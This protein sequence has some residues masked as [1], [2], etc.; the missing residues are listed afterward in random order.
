M[1]NISLGFML[2]LFVGIHVYTMQVI[3]HH[4][5]LGRNDQSQFGFPVSSVCWYPCLYPTNIFVEVHT[6]PLDGA[7]AGRLDTILRYR[8][9]T[10]E[11]LVRDFLAKIHS[12]TPIVSECLKADMERLNGMINTLSP[13][14]PVISLSRYRDNIYIGI[15]NLDEEQPL[16]SICGIKLKREPFFDVVTWGKGPSGLGTTFPE[17]ERRTRHDPRFQPGV[18]QSGRCV[19]PSHTFRLV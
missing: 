12:L 7:T 5:N 15:I 11:S 4:L 10:Y 13:E 2:V 1:P 18:G 6:V 3:E 17:K 9:R 14:E 19:F 8:D 16:H